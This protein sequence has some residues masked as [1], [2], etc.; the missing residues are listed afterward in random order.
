MTSA[1][2]HICYSRSP[3][4]GVIVFPGS[5]RPACPDPILMQFEKS[6]PTFQETRKWL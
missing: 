2:P 4:G 1:F 6:L 5:P 3:P